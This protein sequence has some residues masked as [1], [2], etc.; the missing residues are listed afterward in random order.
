MT[1]PHLLRPFPSRQLGLVEGDDRTMAFGVLGGRRA[2]VTVLVHVPTLLRRMNDLAP[3]IGVVVFFEDATP[4]AATVARID[5]MLAALGAEDGLVQFQMAAEA[6]KLRE[7]DLLVRSV[8]RSQLVSFRPPEVL[9]RK[10]LERA[11]EPPPPDLWVDPAGLVAHAGGRIGL[12]PRRMA[13]RR[14]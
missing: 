4:D 1:S 8:D 12:F 6:I 11:L 10:A 7:G 3:D 9:K 13:D 14:A 5:D 2:G